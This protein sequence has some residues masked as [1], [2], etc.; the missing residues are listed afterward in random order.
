MLTVIDNKE[1][2]AKFRAKVLDRLAQKAQEGKLPP[3]RERFASFVTLWETKKIDIIFRGAPHFLVASAPKNGVSPEADC[4]IALSY[5][6][7]FAQTQGVGTV[8]DG[9]AKWT[10]T[11]IL[12]EMRKELK[13]PDDHLI[14]YA[15]VFGKPA[16]KYSRSVQHG[17]A[18]I[19]RVGIC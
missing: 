10:I 9:L 14:V 2:L 16:V 3:G 6:E 5:F 4:L 13:I 15:M 8:W 17:P 18:N 11:E 19:E 7:L 12:P 1:A